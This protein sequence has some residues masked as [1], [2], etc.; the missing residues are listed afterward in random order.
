VGSGLTP[1]D[2]SEYLDCETADAAHS[3]WQTVSTIRPYKY[4]STQ[5]II[6]PVIEVLK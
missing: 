2:V 3:Q 6:G 4:Q 5:N 1:G